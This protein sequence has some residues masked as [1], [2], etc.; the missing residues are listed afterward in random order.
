MNE[1]NSFL[2][3]SD[4]NFAESANENSTPRDNIFK[5]NTYH[6]TET[7][8]SEVNNNSISLILFNNEAILGDKIHGAVKIYTENFLPIGR[9]EL[10]LESTL[11]INKPIKKSKYRMNQYLNQYRTFIQDKKLEEKLKKKPNMDPS[12]GMSLMPKLPK[13]KKRI[14]F[15][16]KDK[17]FV[18]GG[19]KRLEN[20]G[21]P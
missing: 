15:F 3:Y 16:E 7:I 8:E 1:T 19:V 11:K 21:D 14:S 4:F 6:D 20:N 2:N 10:V 18:L 17:H 13:M 9:V 5:M 12:P